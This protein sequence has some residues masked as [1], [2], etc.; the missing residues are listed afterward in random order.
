[1]YCKYCGRKNDSDAVFCSHCGR[2]FKSPSG[3]QAA[4]APVKKDSG[5]VQP[6]KVVVEQAASTKKTNGFAIAGFVCSLVASWIL[7]LIFSC[8]G[9]AKK[10]KYNRAN[11]LAVAGL[12]IS[13][14]SM[15]AS[16]ALI[17]IIF[18]M[19]IL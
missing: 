10:D 9:L 1:M 12:V 7:G 17:Y 16:I 18:S 15:A 11:G 19:A 8:I 13:L 6:V 4:K 5:D 2:S 3:V 14:V